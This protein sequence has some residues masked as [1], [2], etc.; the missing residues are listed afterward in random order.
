MNRI[1]ESEKQIENVV[2]LTD[3]QVNNLVDTWLEE[4]SGQKT[5]KL[6]HGKLAKNY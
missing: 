3:K 1:H 5:L 2:F 4:C 6:L